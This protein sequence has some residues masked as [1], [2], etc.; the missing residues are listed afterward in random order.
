MPN[1]TVSRV[2]VQ[3]D[4]NLAGNIHGGTILKMIEEAGGIVGI[5]HCN[6]ESAKESKVS[7]SS[8]L[9][10][11]ISHYEYFNKSNVSLKPV[12]KTDIS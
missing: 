5:K 6:Q 9:L 8:I 1:F 10:Q 12:S 2:M 7:T 11:R 4:A 3:D